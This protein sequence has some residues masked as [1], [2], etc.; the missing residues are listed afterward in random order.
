MV[1][2]STLFGKVGEVATEASRLIYGLRF[3]YELSLV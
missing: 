2:I 1:D 3:L